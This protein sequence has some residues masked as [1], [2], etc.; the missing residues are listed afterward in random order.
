MYILKYVID[1]M[2]DPWPGFSAAEP[3]KDCLAID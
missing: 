3:V 2:V 1:F